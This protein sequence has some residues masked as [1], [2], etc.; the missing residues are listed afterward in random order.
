MLPKFHAFRINYTGRAALQTFFRV[1]PAT[2]LGGMI[3]DCEENG[4]EKSTE[5]DETQNT[6]A[7]DAMI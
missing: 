2:L 1:K 6:N 5:A 7:M 4:K 3:H